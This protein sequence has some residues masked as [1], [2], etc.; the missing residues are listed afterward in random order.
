MPLLT[1]RLS[2]NQPVVGRRLHLDVAQWILRC[3]R[4]QYA[5]M[6]AAR[7]LHPAAADTTWHAERA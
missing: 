2:F 3:R 7:A 1:L 5:R 4:H 6:K